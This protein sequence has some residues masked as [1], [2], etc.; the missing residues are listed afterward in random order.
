MSNTSSG[1]NFCANKNTNRMDQKL[2]AQTIFLGAS[3]MDYNCNLGWGT[4]PSTLTVNLVNDN[5]AN[6]LQNPNNAADTAGIGCDKTQH[7]NSY[8]GGSDYVNDYYHA[9]NNNPG[10][11][12]VV[13]Y[14]NDKKQA[15]GIDDAT[16]RLISKIY[17]DTKYPATR[18]EDDEYPYTRDDSSLQVQ[19]KWWA[20]KDPGFLGDLT[21]I[22]KDGLVQDPRIVPT[23]GS[24][25]LS[26]LYASRGYNITNSPVYFKMLD[27]TFGGFVQ[28]WKKNKTNNGD[29]Y[30][31]VVNSA[32]SILNTCTVILDK[33]GGSIAGKLSDFDWSAPTNYVGNQLQ[34]NQSNNSY[35]NIPNI[36][37]VYGFLESFGPKFFGSSS[38]KQTEGFLATQIIDGLRILTGADDLTQRASTTHSDF[39]PKN[40]FSPYGR[41]IAPSAHDPIT[42]DF[43][44]TSKWGLIQPTSG[45]WTG[46]NRCNFRLDLSEIGRS[47]RG[48]N[49]RIQ[50]DSMSIS[51]LI[52]KIC[53][54]HGLDWTTMLINTGSGWVIKVMAVSRRFAPLVNGVKSTVSKLVCDDYPVGSFSYGKETNDA[55]SRSL[56]VGPNQHR[57][58]Q[59]KNTR[60]AYTQSNYIF[61]PGT[62]LN[63][64]WSFVDYY[65]L[66]KINI[67][68]LSSVDC[69]TNTGTR[70]SVNGTT[71]G[72]GKIK[73]PA[74]FSNRNPILDQRVTS[75]KNDETIK[76]LLESPFNNQDTTFEDNELGS[77]VTK[78]RSGNYKD[79]IKISH[80]TDV[81]FGLD[82]CGGGGATLSI[83]NTSNIT[84]Q[85]SVTNR[86]F[87]P[88]YRDVISPF[89]G[90]LL[91]D[92]YKIDAQNGNTDFRRIRPVWYDFWT[93]QICVLFHRDEL[94]DTRIK[95]KG[96][97]TS[98]T[99]NR[100][101]SVNMITPSTEFVEGGVEAEEEEEEETST[102]TPT[103]SY[104]A[105]WFMV[106][107]SEFRA[108][109]AGSDSFMSYT[110]GKIYKSDIYVMMHSAYVARSKKHLED[111]GHDST[112][113]KELALE[114]NN[115]A[116]E[117][118]RTSFAGP[119]GPTAG[120]NAESSKA[121]YKLT[122][123]ARKDF[124]LVANFL[125]SVGQEYYGKKY[126]VMAPFL[127]SK[128]ETAPYK[129][130]L[131]TDLGDINVFKGG[132]EIRY[133]YEP[134]GNGNGA[135]EEYGNQ[136]D[137]AIICGDNNWAALS[138]EKGQIDSILG[139]NSTKAFDYYRYHM[140]LQSVSNASEAMN[141]SNTDSIA[142]NPYFSYS[143][144]D[145]ASALKRGDG[146][147]KNK[148]YFENLNL[149]DLAR[150]AGNFVIVNCKNNSSLINQQFEDAFG[151]V[152]NATGLD[153]FGRNHGAV[154]RKLYKNC[155][156][157]NKFSFLD[158]EKMLDPR[159]I[160]ETDALRLNNSSEQHQTDPSNSV[161]ATIGMEDLAIYT[162][163][164]GRRK[165]RIDF[166][167]KFFAPY[168][169]FDKNIQRNV[170]DSNNTAQNVKIAGKCAHPL[171]AGIAI[172]SNTYCYGPWTN[173]PA[174]LA[175]T[176]IFSTG[177]ET[178]IRNANTDYDVCHTTILDAPTADEKHKLVDNFITDTKFEVVPDFAPW[179]FGGMSALDSVAVTYASGSVNLQTNIEI[180]SLDIA[181]MPLFS[182]GGSFSENTRNEDL[183]FTDEVDTY[184]YKDVKEGSLFPNSFPV[185][186]NINNY[187][188][189][190]DP[191]Y[192]SGDIVY[193]VPSIAIK[194]SNG[195]R[196]GSEYYTQA[197]ILT[198]IMTSMGQNGISTKYSFR[199]Y[200]RKLSLFDKQDVERFKKAAQQNMLRKQEIANLQKTITN[201]QFT[202]K[203]SIK[204]EQFNSPD[205]SFTLGNSP[206]TTLVCSRRAVLPKFSGL[207]EAG[208]ISTHSAPSLLIG[209]SVDDKFVALKHSDDPGGSGHLSGGFTG[210]SEDSQLPFMYLEHRVLTES[211]I[212]PDSELGDALRNSWANSS[213]MSLDGMF[214]PISFYPTNFKT[215][216]NISKYDEQSC[217]ICKGTKK[218]KRFWKVY[219]TSNADSS[220]GTV[221]YY[222]DSCV[223]PYQKLNGSAYSSTFTTTKEGQLYPPYIISSGDSLDELKKFNSFIYQKQIKD[224]TDRLGMSLNIPINITSLQ[225][226]VMPQNEFKNANAQD[227][228]GEHPDEA[229]PVL[230]IDGKERNFRDKGR[231]SISVV[232]KGSIYKDIMGAGFE[233]HN[234]LSQPNSVST[235]TVRNYDYDY[236][237][238]RF[239]DRFSGSNLD[240]L[241]NLEPEQNM[242]F[243]G[244]RGPLMVHGWGYDTEGYPV[245]NA[246]DEPYHIDSY[247]R[248]KRFKLQRQLDSEA[249]EYGNLAVGEPFCTNSD[250]SRSSETVKL[251]SLDLQNDTD[252][253]RGGRTV[254]I[255]DTTSVYKVNYYDDMTDSGGATSEYGGSIISKTQKYNNGSWSKKIKLKQF[256]LNWAERPDIWP[257]GP[258]DLRWDENRQVWTQSAAKVYK[259]VYIT[260]EEDMSKDP[261]LDESFPARGFFDDASYSTQALDNNERKL[262]Y[263]KDR[264]GYT[265]PRGARLFC[266]YDVDTGFYEPLG[267]PQYTVYGAVTPGGNTATITMNYVQGKKRGESAP[268]MVVTF[269]NPLGLS[270]TTGA[271]MFSYINGEW[272]LISSR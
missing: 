89:F 68:N 43:V 93:G 158:P 67:P 256:Y 117:F 176:G 265:A 13:I 206:V 246:A 251:S 101:S 111:D 10:D 259:D 100:S 39:G 76:T 139:Y 34:Y 272:T 37:N 249:T 184:T 215:T 56:I 260:L 253:T 142:L 248:P 183:T 36:F 122:S 134:C 208:A 33:Y 35:G 197:P 17:Y 124:D 269:K 75:L 123:E 266:R 60:L 29:V 69:D 154:K 116:Y 147:E 267:K 162:R 12:G 87:Y 268:T 114:E 51:E 178:E 27:F 42:G 196:M 133:S 161:S 171:F 160:V 129:F 4:Q 203:Q 2:I 92:R 200:T 179:N 216:Y 261:D 130:N 148:F 143:A 220:S 102:A 65:A 255:E 58:Y 135:W 209:N 239:I 231:N 45:K 49:K 170:Y 55:A 219:K 16:A 62:S 151:V 61:S 46:N 226:I 235:E 14:V 153:A 222:C 191:S 164:G 136:I 233:S 38:Y 5:A 127:Q 77:T 84:E 121:I 174:L 137:D 201:N 194:D 247:G 44:T 218:I 257:V 250:G 132:G 223:R 94:P 238:S 165:D 188:T 236:L 182:L 217:P 70:D 97:Y 141:P 125:K 72:Y 119:E 7:G 110:L 53:D 128:T 138:N 90:Y 52:D 163:A 9:F 108:A 168:L 50:A 28:S 71:F 155:S 177:I 40:A 180:G 24:T 131:Q 113:A 258:I 109:M 156:V 190:N 25:A 145:D 6:I 193:K 205:N 107:E 140:A 105:E 167:L 64:E 47:I 96:R 8:A 252:R 18:G 195:N 202:D 234:N 166:L 81:R 224:K 95:M 187:M 212:Y 264:S 186:T 232:G 152:Q 229:H 207:D 149:G 192:I 115:W 11:D 112:K 211:K 91:E 230:K 189:I 23:A 227:Y 173:Y 242:R 98:Y 99:L 126:M 104:T 181:G 41:I 106:T 237:D 19:Q 204:R 254:D 79:S 221:D 82:P 210:Q 243:V 169:T 73:F 157:S 120:E 198:N 185:L 118:I 175:S 63:H 57:L 103:A 83:A 20:D 159:M 59:A 199:T 241:A 144:W 270:T 244:L 3:V 26:T 21:N 48:S 30:T 228:S 213:V 214:S 245:P 78:I 150:D 32:Q 1:R 66:G 262:V 146:L 80:G 172:K 240:S 263:V 225:P 31:V 88:L 271:G 85:T 22:K 15:C 74:F 54:D 86:R